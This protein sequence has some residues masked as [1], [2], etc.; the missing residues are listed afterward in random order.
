MT[1]EYV[2]DMCGKHSL[3]RL[4]YGM[5]AQIWLIGRE[6][7]DEFNGDYFRY[8]F[9]SPDCARKFLTSDKLLDFGNALAHEITKIQLKKA[10][11]KSAGEIEQGRILN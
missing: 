1:V 7:D 8:E 10:M 11:E 9:C 2:C 6:F 4:D 5:S 3:A